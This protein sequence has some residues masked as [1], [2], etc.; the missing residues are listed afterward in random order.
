[1]IVK[2][3]PCNIKHILYWRVHKLTIIP[4]DVILHFNIKRDRCSN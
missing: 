1:M 2:Q 3:F 4:R